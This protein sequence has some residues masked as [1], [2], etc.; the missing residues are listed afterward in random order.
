MALLEVSQSD[1]DHDKAEMK[2][3]LQQQEDLKRA[4]QSIEAMLGGKVD[5]LMEKEPKV[6]ANSEKARPSPIKSK[7]DLKTH[8]SEPPAPPPSAPLPEKPDVARA[9]AD[10]LIQPLLRRSD[11]ARPPSASSSPTRTDHSS[12]ILRLC[13]ELKLAKGELSNQNERMKNLETELAHERTARE[14]AEERAQHLEQRRDSPRDSFSGDL[15]AIEAKDM[16]TSSVSAPD[17]QVQLDK[18]KNSMDEMK[19][20]MEAYRKRAEH[21]EIER[22]E[23]RQSLANMVEQKRRENAEANTVRPNSRGKASPTTSSFSPVSKGWQ[24]NGHAIS[25]APSSPTSDI[26]L[27]RAGV[28]GG[29]PITPEQARILT[30]FLSEQVLGQ[31]GANGARDRDAT[32]YYGVPTASA[33]SILLVGCVIMRWINT[34]EKVDR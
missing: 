11:T 16:Q 29:A 14:S 10:P 32:K 34:W 13:E 15:A 23:A 2:L 17:L 4:R 6:K 28:E 22:D 12:D 1:A 26:L 33:V 8:F 7:T 19:Q 25:P 3:A 30:Q 18:L 27:E 24:P 21:A 9:L 20:Q 31:A 5:P